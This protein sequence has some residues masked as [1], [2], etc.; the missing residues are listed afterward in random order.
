ML[1]VFMPRLFSSAFCK[2]FKKKK[3]L[4]NQDTCSKS[5]SFG[6]PLVI[7][8]SGFCAFTSRAQVRSLV[9]ELRPCETKT[10]MQHGHTHTLI[11]QLL[12][13]EAKNRSGAWIT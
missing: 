10:A 13:G 9:G 7:Q 4:N 6:N 5:H 8:W 1:N 12:I 3:R 11:T 2:W